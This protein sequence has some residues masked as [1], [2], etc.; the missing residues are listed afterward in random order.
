[1]VVELSDL[2][3]TR[4]ATETAESFIDAYYA[5]L[6]GARTTIKDFF[7]PHIEGSTPNRSLPSISYNGEA[8]YDGS[9]FQTKYDE[10][11]YTYY[12][13]QSL[14][15]HVLNPCLDPDRSKTQ[16]EA[17][18]NISISI[19]VSGFIRLAERKDGPTRCF[20]DNFVLVPNKESIGGRGTGRSGHGRQFLIQT[21]SFRFVV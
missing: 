3:R 10:M 7:I 6:T 8:T 14:D 19:Q 15:A 9:E 11:P 20:S 17:E 13:V 12:E 21:Q 4:I 5:A 18:R 2:D 1:M 16:R